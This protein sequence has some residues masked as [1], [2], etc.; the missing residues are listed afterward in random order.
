METYQR[1]SYSPCSFRM[2]QGSRD[3]RI[4]H[5]R[6]RPSA[7]YPRV[8]SRHHCRHHQNYSEN[9]GCG[10]KRTEEFLHPSSPERLTIREAAGGR[11][12]AS[13]LKILENPTWPVTRR[14]I[15]AHSSM[16]FDGPWSL[17]SGRQHTWVRFVQ[18]YNVFLRAMKAS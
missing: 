13:C 18:M 5:I 1:S 17:A 14:C 16:R 8:Q 12:H 2:F 15:M 3:V 4:S 11:K 7:D 9:D 10:K 6:L